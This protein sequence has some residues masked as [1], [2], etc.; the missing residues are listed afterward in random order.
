MVVDDGEHGEARGG[1]V[2]HG[3]RAAEPEDFNGL[4]AKNKAHRTKALNVL[5]AGPGS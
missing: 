5:L 2:A 4:P 1:G 3:A